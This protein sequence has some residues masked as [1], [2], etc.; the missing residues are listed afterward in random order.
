MRI[1]QSHLYNQISLGSADIQNGRMILPG[2]PAGDDAV[3]PLA[4][5]SHSL[6]ESPESLWVGV[7]RGKEI[8][9]ALLRLVL[10]FSRSKGSRQMIPK[11]IEAKVGHL[12]HA[13]GVGGLSLIQKKISG[14]SIEVLMVSPLQE[15]QRD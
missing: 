11:G 10:W 6:Q 7:E 13:A 4:E 5:P 14:G 15:S 3:R 1:G 2:K 9:P 12:E 8:G